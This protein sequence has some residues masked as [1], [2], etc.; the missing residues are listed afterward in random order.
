MKELWLVRHAQ[1]QG[2]AGLK[3]E[4]TQSNPLTELGVQQAQDAANYLVK[5]VEPDVIIHSPYVRTEQTAEPFINQVNYRP[6]TISWQWTDPMMLLP[7]DDKA[8]KPPTPV[9]VWD[10]QE[11]TYLSAVKY[12]NTSMEERLPAREEYWDNMNPDYTDGDGAESF[13]QMIG[14]V[15]RFIRHFLQ[16][17]YGTAVAFTHGQFMK[18]VLCLLQAEGMHGRLPTMGEFYALHMG[19]D[20]PNTGIIKLNF[21]NE[22]GSTRI[23]YLKVKK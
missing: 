9:E 21:C 22:P 19:M 3:T 8:N 7:S 16:S 14:R 17:R 11:Y 12:A 13:S 4:S 18:A 20:I 23:S 5:V 2:N 6:Y 10:I 15:E 1:S